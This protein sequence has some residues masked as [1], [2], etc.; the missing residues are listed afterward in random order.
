M[1]Q[2]FEAVVDVLKEILE[3]IYGINFDRDAIYEYIK[4]KD[5]HMA[6]MRGGLL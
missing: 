1:V 2:C 6:V 5:R 3:A 4:T